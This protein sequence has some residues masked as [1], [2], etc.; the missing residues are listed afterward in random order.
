VPKPA[1]DRSLTALRLWRERNDGSQRA[2]ERY[3][4]IRVARADG[5]TYAEIGGVLGV[6]RQAVADFL[7]SQEQAS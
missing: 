4:L 1:K 5:A 7:R 6:S 2:A 3:A